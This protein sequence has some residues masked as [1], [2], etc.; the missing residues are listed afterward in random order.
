M[1][2]SSILKNLALALAL[3]AIV[4]PGCK[5]DD[6]EPGDDC[7]DDENEL[8]TKVALA[9]SDATTNQ[10][11][12]QFEFSDADGAGGNSPTTDSIILDSATTYNVAIRVYA[13]HEDHTDE[14]TSEILAEDDQHLFCFTPSGAA[15]TVTRTDSD[16]RYEVGLKSR[17]VTGA[18]SNGSIMV[19]LR[20][21]PD[22]KNG[23]CTVGDTD[24]EVNFPVVIRPN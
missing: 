19:V 6:C 4:L 16:G 1:K 23:T 9:F 15:L 22:V 12:Y 11:L 20:H 10:A 14:I 18:A 8:I 21:Q 7:H 24:V 5:R 2:K 3:V 17:W 13:E